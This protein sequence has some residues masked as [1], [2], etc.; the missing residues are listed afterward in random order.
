M[1]LKFSL[2]EEKELKKHSI[3]ISKRKE[4]I[5]NTTS[6]ILDPLLQ[7]KQCKKFIEC[8]GHIGRIPLFETIVHPLFADTLCKEITKICPLCKKYKNSNTEKSMCCNQKITAT[9]FSIRIIDYTDINTQKKY[10]I[11]DYKNVTTTEYA[12]LFGM[13]WFSISEMYEELSNSDFGDNAELKNKLLKIFIKNIPVLPINMRPSIV[14]SNNVNIHNNITSLYLKLLDLNDEYQ[15]DMNENCNNNNYSFKVYNLFKQIIGMNNPYETSENSDKTFIKQLLSGKTGIFRSMCLAKRQNFC[16]RSVI[17]PNIN[18]PLDRILIPKEF[19]DQLISYGYQ[20]NDY[21]IINRQP[22]L[23]TTSLLAVR[24]FP[25]N[26]KTIQINPLIAS[27]FQA[28]FDGD[29]MNVFWLPGKASQKELSSKLNIANNIRSY[30]DASLMIEFIQD[31]LT[32]LYNMTRDKE[33]IDDYMIKR[34]CN[35]LDISKKEWKSFCEYYKS[36]MKSRKVQYNHLISILLPRT[37]SLEINNK[38]VIDNG[39]LVG[40]I[41]GSNQT[42]LLNSI[43]NYGNEFYL[44][45]MWDVQRMVH[46]YNLFH[47][48]TISI[49]DCIPSTDII[50]SFMDISEDMPDNLLEFPIRNLDNIIINQKS[51]IEK[52]DRE[53][54]VCYYY[55]LSKYTETIE[56]NLSNII[57][58][59]SKGNYDNMIQ[60]LFSI[61]VQAALPS[62]YLKGSYSEGLNAKE[63]FI[64][65]K[66]GRAGIIS[67]S[68][69][70]S[71]TGYLQ[72]ELVK[73]MEDLTTDDKGKVYDNNKNKIGYYPFATNL[74]DIDDSFLEYAFSM[75]IKN[76]KKINKS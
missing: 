18:T 57:K 47:T 15:R 51:L 2:F 30:K 58:S 68:L 7:C 12:F 20:P 46:E 27:V 11:K 13:Q 64:H 62:C 61:G 49:A 9:T 52:T 37:L 60:I 25:S 65:S 5:D 22:T 43:T 55:R 33:V 45:F 56:N 44:K 32:G 4:I 34:I 74:P 72:R 6:Y 14:D 67:T 76:D 42:Y 19:T 69:Y 24:S 26:S 50:K 53:D 29:E 31:T 41:N 23:Q 59:G 10:N 66:S 3:L 73:C 38:I 35:K 8:P 71:S 21:V 70:T 28:D 1:L 40:V 75:S 63:L 36:K 17:V 48:I 39:I 16:L 54:L